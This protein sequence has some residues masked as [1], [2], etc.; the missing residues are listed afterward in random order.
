MPEI[1]E[2]LLRRSAE[3]KAKALGLP[4]EQVLAEMRGEAP[5]SEVPVESVEVPRPTF[6]PS[7]PPPSVPEIPPEPQPPD[8]ASA[9]PPAI[10]AV[11]ETPPAAP[12]EPTPAAEEAAPPAPAVP[13]N[14]RLA[15]S[16]SVR[17][18]VPP[19]GV[20]E[21]VRHQRLLTVVKARAIQQVKADPTDKVNTWPHLMIA[22]FTALLAMT[23]FLLVL[24]TILQAPLLEAANFNATPNPSKAPW[25]FLGLQEMLSYFDPQIAGVTVPTVIG[26]VGFMMI[27][28]IDRN[29]ST[30]PSDRKLA[31]MLF[32]IFLAGSATLTI[33]GVLFRG[34][35]FNFAYPW[36]DGVFFD[37]LK[38]WV[39]FGGH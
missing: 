23:A 37:D 18:S 28:Y 31:I 9:P 26:I 25:Y 30:R 13:G 24:S 6:V 22:E 5:V 38:D 4:V 27:P 17:P 15:A 7:P 16:V 12:E 8:P 29:P 35:G 39:D 20:P 36:V 33:L 2:E 32:T 19:T 14:G 1:P 21:G 3:A 11:V 34:P 10:T